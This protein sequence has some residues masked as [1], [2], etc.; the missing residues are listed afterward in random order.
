MVKEYSK[1]SQCMLIEPISIF[2]ETKLGQGRKGLHFRFH[3]YLLLI[4]MSDVVKDFLFLHDIKNDN[5]K[6]ANL[7]TKLGIF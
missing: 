1:F 6:Y 7:H 2:L 4:T 3:F 5:V